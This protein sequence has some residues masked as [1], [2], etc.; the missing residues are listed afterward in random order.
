MSW[1]SSA[2]VLIPASGYWRV[3]STLYNGGS[4]HVWVKLYAA[5]SCVGRVVSPARVLASVYISLLMHS[6]WVWALWGTKPV[7]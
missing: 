3:A 1:V 4:V 2:H 6:T 7:P 5:Q